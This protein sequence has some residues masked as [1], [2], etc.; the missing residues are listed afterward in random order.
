RR[1][2]GRRRRALDRSR[3]ARRGAR[4]V[5]RARSRAGAAGRVALLRRPDRRGNRRGHVDLPRDREAPL[6]GRLRVARARAGGQLAGVTP[7]RWRQI[8]DL[9]HAALE[10]EGDAR[11]AFLREATEGDPDL[12]REVESLLNSHGRRGQF[13]EEPA[14]GV[15]A[16]LILDEGSTLEGRR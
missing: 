8:N 2:P 3:S 9:F 11:K 7:E 4:T 15:G 6:G 10:R 14:Y 5:G 1:S 13:L 16:D 12:L